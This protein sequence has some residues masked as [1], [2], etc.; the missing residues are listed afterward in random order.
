MELRQVLGIRE[1]SWMSRVEREEGEYPL[2][3]VSFMLPFVVSFLS[4]TWVF[5]LN[6]LESKVFITVVSGIR[7][8]FVKANNITKTK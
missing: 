5:Y 1:C 2:S 3:L 6:Y 7:V 8:S 4:G